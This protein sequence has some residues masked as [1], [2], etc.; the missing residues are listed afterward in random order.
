MT[1]DKSE[2]ESIAKLKRGLPERNIRGFDSQPYGFKRE[3]GLR[4]LGARFLKAGDGK[5]RIFISSHC[6]NLIS[7]LLEYKIEIKERDHA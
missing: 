7:E 3:D 1:C 6:I 2:P 4:E 5:P